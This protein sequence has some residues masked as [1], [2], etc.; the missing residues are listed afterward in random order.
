MA[1]SEM[2]F[3]WQNWRKEC[4]ITNMSKL[5]NGTFL[6]NVFENQ[7]ILE[8]VASS[9]ALMDFLP[10]FPLLIPNPNTLPRMELQITECLLW[11]FSVPLWLYRKSIE[12]SLVDV[13][14]MAEFRWKKLKKKKK[15]TLCFMLQPRRRRCKDRSFKAN[16]MLCFLFPVWTQKPT[17]SQTWVGWRKHMPVEVIWMEDKGDVQGPWKSADHPGN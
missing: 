17:I 6:T 13:A 10:F 15:G 12:F 7:L 9:F 16:P 8:I 11:S 1:V 4:K 5:G 14:K 2:L 3:W